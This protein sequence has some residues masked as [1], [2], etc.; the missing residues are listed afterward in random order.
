LTWTAFA[1]LLEL[2]AR[3][4]V[5]LGVAGTAVVA[6]TQWAVRQR[7]LEPFG[8]L[9]RTVRRLSDPL[10]TRVERRLVRW[11]KNPQDAPLWL[12]GFT[13]IGGILLLSLLGWLTGWISQLILLAGASP[14]AWARWGV[15]TAFQIVML[16]LI[17]RVVASWFGKGPYTPWLRLAYRLTDWLVNPIR[18]LLPPFGMIDLSPLVAYVA[19][20]LL[21]GLL[22]ALLL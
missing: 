13:I 16:A 2:L 6:L 14:R 3:Y 11:G 1:S 8:A 17:V 7:H 19:L 22:L 15:N 12:L 4:A 21:R 9:P 5:L 18:R 10:V 20:I